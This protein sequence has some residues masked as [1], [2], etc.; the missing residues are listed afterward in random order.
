MN[1]FAVSGFFVSL[2]D[3]ELENVESTVVLF[4]NH[5]GLLRTPEAIRVLW[6][7]L[8][9]SPSEDPRFWHATYRLVER[10]CTRNHRNHVALSG[11]GLVGSIF[12]QFCVAKDAGT[13]SDRD[14][15]AMQKLLRRLLET[16]VT[17]TA[18]ARIIFQRAV[19]ED[20]T[21]DTDVLEVVRPAMKAKWPAHFS[22]ENHAAMVLREDGVKGLPVGGFTFMVG[23]S[24]MSKR[25]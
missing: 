8:A 17:S 24:R 13:L 4:T 23:S 12:D 1:D 20:D 15:S 14:R 9:E 21:L 25:G 19:R 16:G 6:D 7:L 22:L 3:I 11:L 18:E 10:L 5:F 2:R